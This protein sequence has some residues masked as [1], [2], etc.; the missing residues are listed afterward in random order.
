[1]LYREMRQVR[2]IFLCSCSSNIYIL[3]LISKCIRIRDYNSIWTDL[4]TFAYGWRRVWIPN[5]CVFDLGSSEAIYSALSRH[6]IYEK[7]SPIIFMKAQKNAVEREGM[8]RAHVLDGA[9][10]CEALS[11]LESRVN[12]LLTCN[13][14]HEMQN[15]HS[16]FSSSTVTNYPKCLLLKTSTFPGMHC[17]LTKAPPLEQLL[18]LD[19]M[20][21]CHIFEHSTRRTWISPL[22]A[23]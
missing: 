10:M 15:I 9:A 23:Q 2:F 3:F 12:L 16:L 17:A 14:S 11:L 21:H 20:V 4:R 18:L 1:M 8:Q 22:R 13:L 7:A 5:H 19:H 6:L